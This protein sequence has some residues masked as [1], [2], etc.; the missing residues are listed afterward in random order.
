M[1]ALGNEFRLEVVRRLRREP[2]L[3]H[4]EMLK[5]LGLPRS[6]ASN[7]TKAIEPLEAA[8][9]LQRSGGQYSI[10][11]EEALGR[12]L[13]AAA[14]LD[15]A[16]QRVLLEKAKKRVPEAERLADEIRNE[17]QPGA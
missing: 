3:K 2:G 1:L 14:D 13:A 12:L 6:K 15:V 9:I 17:T 5:A 7:L 8:G 16:A 4:G 11:D 10:V